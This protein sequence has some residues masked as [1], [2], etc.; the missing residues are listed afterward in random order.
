MII[1]TYEWN[2]YEELPMFAFNRLH[3]G[4][5][6]NPFPHRIINKVK[7]DHKIEKNYEAVHIENEYLDIILLPE[8]GGRIFSAKDKTNGYDF[9][10]RHHV[11][12]PALIGI[13]GLWISG[14]MEFNWARHHRPATFMQSDFAVEHLDDGSIVVWMSEHDPLFRMKGMVGIAVHPG[15][16]FFETRMKIYNRTS[17]PH[18]FHWWENAGVPVNDQ[19][20]VFFPPDVTYV[21][22]H[23]RKATGAYPIM[24]EYFSNEDNRGGVDVRF[25]KNS[26]MASSYF[27]GVSKYDFFGG[28][29]HG[30]N[31]GVIHF[32]SHYTSPGKKMFT[33]GTTNQAKAWED[34]LTDSDGPYIELMAS[35]YGDNQPDFSWIE[36]FET[37][38]FSQTWY[39]YKELGEVQAATD[40][41]ALSYRV[42][43]NTMKVNLY[44]TENLPGTTLDIKDPGGFKVSKK[45]S[46][47]AAKPFSL[48]FSGVSGRDGLCFRLLTEAGDMILDYTVETPEAYIPEPISDIPRPDEIKSAED[49]CSAGNHID[50]YYDPEIEP[51][52]YWIKGLEFDPRHYGCLLGL[53]RYELTRLNYQEAEEYLRRAI[54]SIM[55]YNGN[56]RDGEALYLLGYLLAR[57]GAY[58][59]A[60]EIL[61]KCLWNT[62][63][64]I[65]SSCIIAAI[66]S[67]CGAYRKAEEILCGLIE[68]KGKNQKAADML[69]SIFR[70]EMKTDDAKNLAKDLLKHDFLDLYALNELRI[71]GDSIP[72]DERFRY[73]RTETGM[74]LAG[75]YADMGLYEDGVNLIE[76]ICGREEA[77]YKL[78]YAAGFLSSLLGKDDA[79][80]SWY[81][82]AKKASLGARFA[83]LPFEKEVLEGVS[84]PDAR[85]FNELGI[86]T[87]GE[88]RK[89]DEA[90][91]F[92]WKAH[93]ADPSSSGIMR[94]LAVGLFA[95]DNKQ[96]EV[97]ALMEKAIQAKPGDLQLLYERNIVADLQ[98]LSAKKRLEIWNKDQDRNNGWDGLILQG[99]R[100]Y[101]ETGGYH[102]ALKLLTSH[103]F[104]PA[105]GGEFELALEY[106]YAHEA[107]GYD[108][109][110]RGDVEDSLNH[111][112][113][114]SN[115]PISIGGGMPHA[116]C[117]SP[118]RYGEALALL[119]LGRK[120]EAEEVFLWIL[121]FPV[122]YFTKSML[123]SSLYYRAMALIGL[124][125]E[126][127]GTDLLESLK[128][129]EEK[130]LAQKEYGWS[131]TTS[132]YNSFIRDPSVNKLIHHLVLYARVLSGLGLKE[133]ASRAL[134]R[135]FKLDPSNKEAGLLK[136]IL[137]WK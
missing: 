103:T 19:Y 102:E 68:T 124:R 29:D 99:I 40:R 18:A 125:R 37:K 130:I 109:L 5:T 63:W 81:E 30:R 23:Y 55:R 131:S 10:Y 2:D 56:P 71:L 25:Y 126:R 31:S 134:D 98:G 11:I 45:I 44:A 14:G 82:K 12:K 22:F 21:N 73:R 26:P 101:N 1:P 136:G 137:Y 27:C 118:Y 4:T 24:D 121:S 16:A 104:I 67:K 51:S 59:E 58:D 95:Q 80:A 94:N 69:I 3:Q 89:T 62:A 64:I 97:L 48:D 108:A 52:A 75:D 135:V 49:L 107:L 46:L 123:P 65:P 38:E 34:A 70:K 110:K 33:W 100:L 128:V 79:A 91:V 74:D 122:N 39:P 9:L 15:K 6:G 28:Y 42:N 120:Q 43:G 113:E 90:L 88:R 119:K 54:E 132:A 36:P 106:G 83:S 85:L 60:L 93:L 13:Y 111:F 66:Y 76:W 86:L 57:K 53:G 41:V 84:P 77:D 112:R 129:N 116:V 117:N 20:Q 127:E 133:Q 92:W 61:H 8:L 78:L 50:Q 114:A 105:E 72:A 7:R 96:P 17:M 87:F 115:P 47:E 32:A 35:S